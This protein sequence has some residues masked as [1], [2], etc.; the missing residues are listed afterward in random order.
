MTPSTHE[1]NR[2]SLQMPRSPCLC[3]HLLPSTASSGVAVAMAWWTQKVT[4]AIAH[5]E[6]RGGVLKRGQG[7]K[8]D[9][10]IE[11]YEDGVGGEA[12][13]ALILSGIPL[14][15]RVDDE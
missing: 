1:E 15:A 6:P 5:R 9:R 10:E 3:S 2:V 4:Q 8:R 12:V 11:G 13:D 14:G 7:R